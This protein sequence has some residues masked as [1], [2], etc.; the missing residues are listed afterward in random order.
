MAGFLVFA[1]T[2][3]SHL[4]H[5][6]KKSQRSQISPYRLVFPSALALAHLALAAAESLA[7]VAGRLRQSF[8]LAGLGVAAMPLCLAH[9]ALAA[10]LMAALPAALN[11][12]LPFLAGLESVAP[13]PLIL[14]HLACCA[15]AIL[16]LTAAD[17][18]RFLGAFPVN[19]DGISPPP[20]PMESS[21]LSSVSICSL[22]AMIWL[23]WLVVNSVMF[24]GDGLMPAGFGV[25]Q[26]DGALCSRGKSAAPGGQCFQA[27]HNSY[28]SPISY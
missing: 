11:R 9:L 22:M 20:E 4:C 1:N 5:T 15:A 6:R 18:R 10:A 17:L 12:L 16:A 2:A 13:V 25:N 7:L 27:S 8:F 28:P 14:A 19:V 3:I 26:E 21:W 23:S 24:M